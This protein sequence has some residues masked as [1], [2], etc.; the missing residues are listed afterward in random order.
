[1]TPRRFWARLRAE[2]DYPLRRGAWYHVK[3][4]GPRE[5]IVDVVGE[6][7]GIP[8]ADLEIMSQPPRRWSV[9]PRPKNPSRFPGVSEYGVCPN[10]RERVPLP[11][12]LSVL[13][14]TRCNGAFDVA[15]E[16]QYLLEN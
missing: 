10:C 4:L 1:V 11:E 9:V 7:V 5:A 6:R 16:E 3:K 12:R 13:R 14:C 2:S 8:R 15:W